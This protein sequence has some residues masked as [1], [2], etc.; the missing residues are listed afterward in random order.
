MQ[1]DGRFD[2]AFVGQILFRSYPGAAG[3]CRAL[4]AQG[5]AQENAGLREQAGCKYF[6]A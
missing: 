2:W 4:V 1:I 5:W 6:I 3:D